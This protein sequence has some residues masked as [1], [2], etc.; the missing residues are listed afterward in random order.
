MISMFRNFAKSKWAIGLIV[1]VG[2]GLLVTGG[3]QT[4]ILGSL[5]PPK[6]VSAGDR[7][8]SPQEFRTEMDRRL[9]QIQTEQR[10]AVTYEELLA[11]VPMGAIL[12]GRAEEMA[13][14]AWAWKT[15]IRPGNELI[16]RQIRSYPAFFDPI[17]GQ[18]SETLYAS[19]L[20]QAK[21][22]P[23]MLEE[24]IRNDYSRTHYATAMI[25]GMRLPRV[26][27]AVYANQTQQSRDGRWFVLTQAMAGTAP[28][29]TDAQL[30]SF[31]SQHA[32]ELRIPELR[33]GTLVIFANPADQN[34][35]IS[36]EKIQARYD[37][38]KDSLSQPERRTFTTLSAP[39]QAAAER[40]AAALRAGQTPEAVGEAN[41][42]QP[43][44]YSETPRSAI[45]DPAVAA[46]V[47]GLGVDEISAPV[48]ARVGFVVAK[49]TGVQEGREVTLE[50]A[51]D[52][53][54]QELRGQEA[55]GAIARRV[56]AFEEARRA[57]KGLDEAVREV[58]AQSVP[59]PAVSREGQN[60]Q[61]QQLNVPAPVLEAMWKLSEGRANDPVGLGEGQ[62][63][64]VRVDEVTPAAMPSLDSVRDIV[65]QAWTASENVRLLSARADALAE[66]LRAGEDIA[67]V[68]ASV[69]ANVVTETGLKQEQETVA[70]LGRGVAMGLFNGKAGQVFSQPQSADSMVIG[71]IGRITAPT[72]ALA[73]DEAQQW[74]ARL[75]EA[76]GEPLLAASIAAAA[77]RMDAT[78]D[79]E[80][81]RQALG[82][83]ETPATPAGR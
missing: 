52:E 75:G 18:F 14:F 4:D 54:V 78:Y 23:A 1:L 37:F 67:A 38:R 31:M 48:Q 39:T 80:L 73:V 72:A 53:I 21:M 35:A 59:I 64:V 74:R 30:N 77:E 12:K 66:R 24:E 25:A 8:L 55:R 50:D 32:S 45:S 33:S 60:R 43:A 22:T 29:P 26:Y 81:G 3:T 57:G 46:A 44:N 76:S 28:R 19:Q 70:R 10:R 58:G 40:I 71:K 13:F 49:V 16:L 47:F 17:T 41:D 79:E 2:L 82:V 63:F 83:T 27:G 20:G 11:Q 51:R 68:A 15:G 69:G 9:Q 5:Q 56:E 42:L 6:V 62:Y 36:E 7:S 34:I 61:G 65:T